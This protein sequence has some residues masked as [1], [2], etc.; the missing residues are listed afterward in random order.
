MHESQRIWCKYIREMF[1][2]HFTNKQVLEVGSWDIN[3][4]N[5]YLFENCSI[6]HVDVHEGKNVDVAL[7]IHLLQTNLLFDTI[8]S[9]NM[10]EHDMHWLKSISKMIELLKPNG[11]LMIQSFIGVE[12]G[13]K[14]HCEHDSL[15]SKLNDPAWNNHYYSVMPKDMINNF[16]LYSI[17]KH[18]SLGIQPNDP[19]EDLL[20]WGVKR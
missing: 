5:N 1:P 15:T 3:G 13:T 7:P 4:N 11:F 6:L 19:N 17:F 12:H 2:N 18:F 9:T 16:D 8:I 10:L 20:F 14:K